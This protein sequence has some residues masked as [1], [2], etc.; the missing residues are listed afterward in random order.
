MI[1]SCSEAADRIAAGGVV[2][3][4][5]DTVYGLVCD[6]RS[7]GAVD[8]IYA[9]KRR[10]GALEL[11]LLGATAEDLGRCGAMDA[12]AR[13]LAAAL[14][15]GALSIIVPVRPDAGLAVP[16]AGR[17]VSLRVPAGA[18][19][20]EL[21]GRTGPLASTSANRHGEPAATTAAECVAALGDEIDGVLD[22]GRSAGEGSTIIDL[23]GDPPRLLRAGPISADVLAAHLGGRPLHPPRPAGP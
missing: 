18:V 21:L 14:W 8:R 10:P 6:P 19:A 16:R 11:G 15:P 13:A 7:A 1:L 22:G 9:V 12:R 3:I 2:A 23:T 4:A 20:R 5:T 17:T